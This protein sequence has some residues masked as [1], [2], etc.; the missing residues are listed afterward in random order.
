PV[1]LGFLFSPSIGTMGAFIKILDKPR[2][3]RQF[4]DIGVAGPL[5]G[6]VVAIIVLFIGFRTLPPPEHI[7][8]LHPEYQIWGDDYADIVYD[9]DTVI[10]KKD[11][12]HL[13]PHIL[14]QLDDSLR[15]STEL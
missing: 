1:W 6:F 9:L 5:A 2:T 12:G 7:Y 3:T 10:Y 11:L 4:F 15:F 14:N 8:T 13:E